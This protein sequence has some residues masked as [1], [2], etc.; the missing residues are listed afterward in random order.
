MWAM[1]ASPG[2]LQ[3]AFFTKAAVGALWLFMTT[4]LRP[5]RRRMEV[6]LPAVTI[7]SQPMTRSAQAIP[8]RVVRIASW[9]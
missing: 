3:L 5:A 8:T 7:G 2:L 1:H 4:W 9:V 6:S